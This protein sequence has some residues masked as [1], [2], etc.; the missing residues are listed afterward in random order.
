M[1]QLMD[2]TPTAA[3]DAVGWEGHRISFLPVE[4]T[5]LDVSVF[6]LAG[7]SGTPSGLLCLGPYCNSGGHSGPC[8]VT[9]KINVLCRLWCTYNPSE[10]V[11][12]VQLENCVAQG[13][14]P[15]WILSNDQ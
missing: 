7:T 12:S 6:M 9:L 15:G 8:M 5:E 1:Q 4:Q 13:C 3:A 14:T 2:H 10:A 11:H